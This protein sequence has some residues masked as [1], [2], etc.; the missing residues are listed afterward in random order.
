MGAAL[1]TRAIEWAGAAGAHKVALEVWPDNEGA[2]ALYRRAGFEPEGWLR[3]HYRPAQRRDLGCD[4][5]WACC[6]SD[7]GPGSTRQVTARGAASTVRYSPDS[8]SRR[9]RSQASHTSTKRV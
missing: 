9:S 6:S 5:R 7:A 8:S 3:S 4:R 1:L 2:L